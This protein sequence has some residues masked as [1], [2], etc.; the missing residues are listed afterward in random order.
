MRTG[1]HYVPDL[2][3]RESGGRGA[4]VM[5]DRAKKRVKEILEEHVPVVNQKQI[6]ALEGFFKAKRRGITG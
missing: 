3:N 1:E 2:T 5:L 4:P 6:A